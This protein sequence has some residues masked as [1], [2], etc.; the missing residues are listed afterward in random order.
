[1]TIRE[2]LKGAFLEPSTPQEAELLEKK[3]RETEVEI[4]GWT[5]TVQQLIDLDIPVSTAIV[6]KDNI[7]IFM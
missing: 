2:L 5:G 6:Q 1:M 4:L 3:R 7:K